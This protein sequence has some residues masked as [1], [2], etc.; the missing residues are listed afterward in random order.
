MKLVNI[1]LK[2]ISCKYFHLIIIFVE[3]RNIMIEQ[4]EYMENQKI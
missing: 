2:E 4:R 1:N 3:K